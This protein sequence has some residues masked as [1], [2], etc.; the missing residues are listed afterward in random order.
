MKPP[1][2][3]RPLT[4]RELEAQKAGLHSTD[5]FVVRRYQIL[6]ASVRGETVPTIARAMAGNAPHAFGRWGLAAVHAGS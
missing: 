2:F 1:I 4:E 5:A 3:V 6:L